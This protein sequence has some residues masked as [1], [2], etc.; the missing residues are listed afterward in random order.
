MK[1]SV[2]SEQWDAEAVPQEP[3]GSIRPRGNSP[4]ARHLKRTASYSVV[5]RV[6]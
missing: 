6:V 3:E 4:S 1:Y 2:F 5:I